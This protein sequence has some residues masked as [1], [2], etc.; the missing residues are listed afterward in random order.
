MIIGSTL[1]GYLPVLFGVPSFSITAVVGSLI[2]G[3]AGIW[4]AVKFTS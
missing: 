1:G 3:L 4:L 2:G